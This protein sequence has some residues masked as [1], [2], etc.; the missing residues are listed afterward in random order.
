[1]SSTGKITA[2]SKTGSAVVT[3]T[4]ASGKTARVQVKVQKSA[5]QTTKISGLK[6]SITL[7]VKGR[8][9]LRP[10]ISPSA[11]TQKVT[12]KSSNKKVVTVTA[13]GKVT[14]KKRGKAVITV[15]SG[16]KSVKVSVRV[17]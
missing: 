10:V 3:V 11:S 16:K 5:V 15:K 14:A 4:L 6:K 8:T 9:T 17:K 1:M 13:S 7:K 12:Y 2:K